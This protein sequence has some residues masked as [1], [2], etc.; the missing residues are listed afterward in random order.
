M[1]KNRGRV[2]GQRRVRRMSDED[3]VSATEESFL[4]WGEAI[5]EQGSPRAASCSSSEDG[6]LSPRGE[7]TLESLDL[8]VLEESGCACGCHVGNVD[9]I[10]QDLA[11]ACVECPCFAK[12]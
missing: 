7:Q 8:S 3:E 11:E 1:S 12:W 6:T 2:Q 10:S 4:R 9:Y 5:S